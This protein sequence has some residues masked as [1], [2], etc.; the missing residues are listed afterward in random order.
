MPAPEVQVLPGPDWIAAHLGG[1][2][3]IAAQRRHSSPVDEAAYRLL[4]SK[5]AALEEWE[6]APPAL[7]AQWIHADYQWRN[8]IFDGEDRPIAI[9]DFDNLR[10]GSA[11]HEVMR[12]L[13]YSFPD[14]QEEAFAF[15]EGYA[16]ASP[17]RPADALEY[18]RYWRYNYLFRVW[19]L[20]ER[21]LVP[22]LYQP[23]W[24][25]FI[26]PHPEWWVVNHDQAAERLAAIAASARAAT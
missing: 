10:V 13:A 23:R 19:P 25:V 9:V 21:Y 15:F 20:S 26:H 7:P 11:G 3:T 14:G 16:R 4:T 12:C 22:E 5:L 2:I 8:V 17:I 6:G 18:V 24:D 1:L